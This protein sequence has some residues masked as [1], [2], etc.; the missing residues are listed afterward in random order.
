MSDTPNTSNSNPLHEQVSA[1]ADG[2]VS[3]S[4]LDTLSKKLAA[5]SRLRE[6]LAG[7]Q[8]I[9]EQLRHEGPMVDASGIAAAVSAQL[10][11]EPTVLAP[12]RR[13]Q[14]FNVPRIAMGAALAAT[15]AAVAVGIAPQVLDSVEEPGLQPQTFAFAPQLPIPRIGATTVS[16][17]G[18]ELAPKGPPGDGKQVWKVLQPK[19]QQKMDKYLLQHNEVAGRMGVKHLNAHVGFG[20]VPNARP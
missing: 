12:K 14:V 8:R 17:G 10:E 18:S 20:S 11:D 2:E 4:E 15:V 7:Y 19:V 9:G 16:L 13:R 5:D 1:L 3:S 6:Q